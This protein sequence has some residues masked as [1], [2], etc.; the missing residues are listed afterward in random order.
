MSPRPVELPE[1]EFGPAL[2]SAREGRFAEALERVRSALATGPEGGATE[3][4]AATALSEISRLA[5]GASDLPVAEQAIALAV[6]LKPRFPDLHYQHA[7]VL[8][9]RQR[10]P[11]ARRAL[12]QALRIHPRFT[13]AR[14]ELALLDAREGL[15]S[16]SL[17]SLRGL[18][19]DTSVGDADA[20]QEGLRS[21]ERAEW[22]EAEPLLRRA[23]DLSDPVLQEKLRRFQAHLEAGE[24]ARALPILEEL[25][26][27][28]D[29]Y[30][31]L[32]YLA[33]VAELKMGRH[34]DALASFARAL[35][36]NPR[37]LE[38]RVQLARTLDGLGDP[39]RAAEQVARVLEVEPEN[40]G[41]LE[42]RKSWEVRGQRPRRETAAREAPAG[43]RRDRP[44][45][46]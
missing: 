37:F 27:R 44:K 14:L 10:R 25:L 23:L 9:A 5:E 40:R 11:E 36:I 15:I 12:E 17:E 18:A 28:Y 33:G 38:A 21:I 8:L 24:T 22:D 31:D 20:F 29:G 46:T 34:D 26:P 2:R 45:P 13:A 19:R 6:E 16:E 4:T 30:P 41:A 3:A 35:E 32:H 39:E 1:S 43:G 7:C 42:L